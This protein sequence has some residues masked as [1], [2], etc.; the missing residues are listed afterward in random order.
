MEERTE[1]LRLR[2]RNISDS[3]ALISVSGCLDSHTCNE[4]E[5]FIKDLFK[6][7]IY[8]IIFQLDKLDYISSAGAGVFIDAAEIAALHDGNIVLLSLSPDVKELFDLLGL[9]KVFPLAYSRDNAIEYLV[10]SKK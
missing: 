5:S 6:K 9:S 3:I 4:L 2:K 10:G 7:K 8:R 1:G